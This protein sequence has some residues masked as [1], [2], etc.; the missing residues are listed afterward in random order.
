AK[1]A[2]LAEDD[3]PWENLGKCHGALGGAWA[4]DLKSAGRRTDVSEPELVVV[5]LELVHIDPAGR[6]ARVEL[7]AFNPYFAGFARGSVSLDIEAVQDLSAD[8]QTEIALCVRATGE[9]YRGPNFYV[10]QPISQCDLF[11]VAQPDPARA[12]EVQRVDTAPVARFTDADKDGRLDIVSAQP[13]GYPG[14][15]GYCS[16]KGFACMDGLDQIAPQFLYHS[17]PGGFNPTDGAAYDFA[18]EQC[19][20]APKKSDFDVDPQLGAGNMIN[21]VQQ[22]GCSVLYRVPTDQVGG[23]LQGAAS[24]LCQ[25]P[26]DCEEFQVLASWLSFDVPIDLS[27]PRP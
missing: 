20:K 15:P 1:L 21:I 3:F 4:L 11:G 6:E 7:P 18:K 5:T 26:G 14:R 10:P 19:P 23:W 25:D 24:Q 9:E 2:P 17:I 27:A 16:L 8:A 13:F 12:A 22:V